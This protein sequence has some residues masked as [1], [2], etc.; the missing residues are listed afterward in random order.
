MKA[1]KTQLNKEFETL[2]RD[3]QIKVEGLLKYKKEDLISIYCD[4]INDN[5]NLNLEDKLR[6]LTRFNLSMMIIQYKDN[7]NAN[8]LINKAIT[9]IQSFCFNTTNLIDDLSTNETERE[10]EKAE[11]FLIVLLMNAKKELK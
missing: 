8:K 11:N 5:F 3:Q 7:K 9:E 10:K 2:T 6:N 4:L 1:T